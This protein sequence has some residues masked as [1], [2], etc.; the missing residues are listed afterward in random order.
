MKL[1]CLGGEGARLMD[2]GIENYFGLEK[3][4]Y[5]VRSGYGTNCGLSGIVNDLSLA[6]DSY[7]LSARR[8]VCVLIQ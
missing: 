1:F 3:G 2:I 8:T 7:C 6:R 5:E 4:R